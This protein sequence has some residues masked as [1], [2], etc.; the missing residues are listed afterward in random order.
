MKLLKGTKTISLN[1]WLY[2]TLPVLVQMKSLKPPK[3]ITSTQRNK[4]VYSVGL[5][6][7]LLLY[8]PVAG[9]AQSVTGTLP[10]GR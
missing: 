10:S 3:I 1:M 4:G 8:H 7:A 2:A 6:V 9:H 5:S